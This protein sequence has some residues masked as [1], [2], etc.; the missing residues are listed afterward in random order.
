MGSVS[1]SEVFHLPAVD[2]IRVV[3]A[4]WDSIARDPD[5]IPLGDAQRALLDEYYADYLADPD[6]GSPWPEVKARLLSRE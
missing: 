1:L 2:R 3:Q 6:I 4:L 5:Q